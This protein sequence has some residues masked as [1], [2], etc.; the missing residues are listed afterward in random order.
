MKPCAGRSHGAAGSDP[1]DR[2][3]LCLVA[4]RAVTTAS[5]S[6]PLGSAT[7]FPAGRNYSSLRRRHR[8]PIRAQATGMVALLPER[9]SSSTPPRF[10]QSGSWSTSPMLGAVAGRSTHPTNRV[11]VPRPSRR[12]TAGDRRDDLSGSRLDPRCPEAGSMIPLPELGGTIHAHAA[13]RSARTGACAD[14]GDARM[15]RCSRVYT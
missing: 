4:W 15:P 1:C 14:P 11:Q 8:R 5:S 3:P 7:S 6:S 10:G 9:T 12:R 2:R 13:R